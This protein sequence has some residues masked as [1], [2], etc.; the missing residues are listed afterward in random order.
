MTFPYLSLSGGADLGNDRRLASVR[1]GRAG[2]EE[3]QVSPFQ[4]P[5]E[6]FLEAAGEAGG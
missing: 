6:K 5:A 4:G 2:R 1:G 3:L